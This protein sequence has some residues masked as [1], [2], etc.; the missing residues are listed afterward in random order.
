MHTE[1]ATGPELVVTG[2]PLAL[3]GNKGEI[4]RMLPS[5]VSWLRFISKHEAEGNAL[6]NK[7]TGTFD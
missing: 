4:F 7:L 6:S 3:D 5:S 1:R 2:D